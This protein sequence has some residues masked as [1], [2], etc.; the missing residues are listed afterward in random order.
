M[1]ALFFHRQARRNHKR[2]SSLWVPAIAFTRV[3]YRPNAE[4]CA[5]HQSMRC[6]ALGAQAQ[7][8]PIKQ[9]QRQPNCKRKHKRN[10]NA[11]LGKH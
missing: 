2:K 4:P 11:A 8:E 5:H 7:G 10:H 1:A 9:G 3:I 6:S